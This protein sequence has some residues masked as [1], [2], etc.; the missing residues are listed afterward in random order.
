MI[1]RGVTVLATLLAVVVQA[2]TMKPGVM[3]FFSNGPGSGAVV[4]V[5]ECRNGTSKPVRPGAE[6]TVQLWLD[7]ELY[8]APGYGHMGGLSA[9]IPPGESW[10]ELVALQPMVGASGRTLS[11]LANQMYISMDLASGRHSVAFEC[12]GARSDDVLFFWNAILK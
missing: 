9:P 2:Q 8:H 3:P 1:D 12:G 10:R 11:G 6:Q 7:G 4:F 5:V